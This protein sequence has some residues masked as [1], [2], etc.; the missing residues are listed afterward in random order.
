MQDLSHL[1]A[2]SI[3]ATS[4]AGGNMV[5]SNEQAM[6][7]PGSRPVDPLPDRDK[8]GDPRLDVPA[9]TPVGTAAARRPVSYSPSP[10]SWK[11]T[12]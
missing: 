6:T 10:V 7:A 9:A 8:Q 4:Q 1:A 5:S 3:T 11:D 12:E 2:G